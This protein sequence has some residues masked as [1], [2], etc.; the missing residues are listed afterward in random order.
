[1]DVEVSPVSC[2]A[3]GS[4]E[5]DVSVTL[6]SDVPKNVAQLPDYLTGGGKRFP[7]GNMRS[8]L[9]VYAPTGG[10]ITDV[11]SSDGT[12]SVTTRIHDGLQVKARTLLLKPGESV[13]T[14]YRIDS[15]A[16]LR[17]AIRVRTTPGPTADRFTVSVE[18]CP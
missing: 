1:M 8:N 3:G 13:T 6:T 18:Q 10:E 15:G 17:G 5:H 9:L 11:R 12:T 7:V 4:R 14:T 2:E 16:P